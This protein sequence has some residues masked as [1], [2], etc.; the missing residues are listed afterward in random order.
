VLPSKPGVHLS[1]KLCD[2]FFPHKTRS[3]IASITSIT[4]MDTLIG[5]LTKNL[6][7]AGAQKKTIAAKDKAK[8]EQKEKERLAVGVLAAAREEE[9][10]MTRKRKEAEK[11]LKDAKK[12]PGAKAPPEAPPDETE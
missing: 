5:S 7:A 11:A 6:E 4:E 8:A 10:D 12:K 9:K 3:G 2:R 1:F